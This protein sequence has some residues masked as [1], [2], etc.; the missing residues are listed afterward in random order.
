MDTINLFKY[1]YENYNLVTIKKKGEKL[2]S[3]DI[4]NQEGNIQKID[5]ELEED[6]SVINGKINNNIEPKIQL[7]VDSVPVKKGEVV[8]TATYSING[9]DYVT[10]ILAAET[11]TQ[12]FKNNNESLKMPIS[13]IIIVLI[14]SIVIGFKIFR[15]KKISNN[16]KLLP[17]YIVPSSYKKGKH[18]L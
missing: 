6:I 3:V 13:L 9:E 7:N 10:N 11:L 4:K 2:T 15:R 18:S 8:G 5:V 16:I 12:E 14:I 1:G 17:A